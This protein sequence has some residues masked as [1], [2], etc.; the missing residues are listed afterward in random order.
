MLQSLMTR[1]RPRFTTLIV[2]AAMACSLPAQAL[3]PFIA[4][5][6]VYNGGKE[7]GDATMQVV[8]NDARRWR[9]DLGI[10]GTTGLMGLAG[11]NAE[12]STVFDQVGDLYRP[13]TQGTV[14]KA[15][16]TRRQTI[17]IYDW[18]SQ[19]ARWQGDIK[20]ERQKPIGLQ[21]GDMSGL[22]IN[23]AVIRDAQPGRTLQ[24]RFVD[25]G[26]VRPHEYV[27]SSDTEGVK[28]GDM[29]FS[30]MR[31]NRVQSGNEE[32]VIW[33]VDG[34][35]T[36]VRILQRENGQDTYDLRLVEYKGA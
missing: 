1:A 29:S 7:M 4:H 11:V 14:K 20:E 2:A 13:L 31:V 36:P 32:T 27:V 5:Y 23:L 35:P 17:G 12:Q 6:Q 10:H 9:V 33:V 15:L 26:R 30:A 24:Y 25:N 16:F 18:R 3:E 34:V 28:V 21:S 22:L 19:T 8:R